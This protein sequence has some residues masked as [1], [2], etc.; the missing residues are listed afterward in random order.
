[1]RLCDGAFGWCP[2]VRRRDA[3]PGRSRQR[4][5]RRRR[6]PPTGI[7]RGADLGTTAGRTILSGDV[8]QNAGRLERSRV[9]PQGSGT[10][11]RTSEAASTVPML[12]QGRAIGVIAVM[13]R[14][15]GEFSQEQIRAPADV[16]R[17]GGHRRRERAPV[18]RAGGAQQRADG[19]PRAADGDRRDPACHL[20]LSDR[21][22]AGL[23]GDRRERAA[24]LRGHLQHRHAHRCR[25]DQGRGC[26]G[27]G[28]E[29]GVAAMRQAYPR[30]I[31]RDTTTG[32][33]ILDRRAGPHR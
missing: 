9:R 23:R 7:S 13:R 27:R 10:S 29:A 15:P 1:M 18:H 20:G 19:G 14:E 31:A 5:L 30:P 8:V 26:P 21:R 17:P 16:R 3:S 6:R 4:Q 25:P 11:G 12:H 32:R 33:A 24:A 28:V 22:A 2:D